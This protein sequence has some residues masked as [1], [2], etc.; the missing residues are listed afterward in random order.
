V[1]VQG[2][3]RSL[4]KLELDFRGCSGGRPAQKSR[5]FFSF[6]GPISTT[7][8]RR[9][10][11]NEKKKRPP[12]SHFFF[13]SLIFTL[14]FSPKFDIHTFFFSKV[15]HH[16][17][18]PLHHVHTPLHHVHTPLHHDVENSPSFYTTR[19]KLSHHHSHTI[20]ALCARQE[21]CVWRG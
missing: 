1:G 5:F 2:V 10:D 17:H 6:A 15:F 11:E 18:T 19:I 12:K 7:E 3:T 4:N 8:I 9:R 13:Q 16:V 14:F 21:E 20:T